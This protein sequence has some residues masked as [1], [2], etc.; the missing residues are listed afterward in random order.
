MRAWGLVVLFVV[1][2]GDDKGVGA[3]SGEDDPIDAWGDCGMAMESGDIGGDIA[4][5]VPPNDGKNIS[6]N[7]PT[8][9]YVGPDQDAH[10]LDLSGFRVTEDG[11]SKFGT[12]HVLATGRAVVFI[13]Y[14]PYAPDA[15]VVLA[16]GDEISTEFHTAGFVSEMASDPNLSFEMD[17]TIHG[18][19]CD[20]NLFTE[21]FAIYGDAA[22][23]DVKTGSVDARQGTQRL[24]MSTGEI[25]GGAAEGRTSSYMVSQPFETGGAS[26]LTFDLRMV[27]EDSQD[28]SVLVVLYG[29]DGVLFE[30]VASV[31]T[32]VG[33]DEVAFPGMVDAVGSPWFRF[34][35][36]DLTQIGSPIVMTLI[37]ADDGG[38]DGVTGIAVD[39]IHLD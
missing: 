38:W 14:E 35:L 18:A 25:L 9:L 5:A 13:P 23:S 19:E 33:A 30:E 34:T 26:S 10:D 36:D 32:S 20:S 39:D 31:A 15:G 8:V 3:S 29:P 1:G 7:M 27:S 17:V 37:V 21:N 22:V 12:V 2:C 28:D 24:L 16:V 11:S 6:P 4:M